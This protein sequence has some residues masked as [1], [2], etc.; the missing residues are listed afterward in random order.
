MN[1]GSYLTVDV[2]SI[3]TSAKGKDL[4]VQFKYRESA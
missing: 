2:T 3:G 1:A 4:V